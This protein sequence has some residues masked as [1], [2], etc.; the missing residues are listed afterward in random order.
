MQKN[1]SL[2]ISKMKPLADHKAEMLLKTA[3]MPLECSF[4]YIMRIPF[5]EDGQFEFCS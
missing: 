3:H 4:K 2:Q 1:I 5:L